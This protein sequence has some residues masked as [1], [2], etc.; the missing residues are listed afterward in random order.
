M[1]N[2]LL[3]K[4]VQA[5]VSFHGQRGCSSHTTGSPTESPH[6]LSTTK[7]TSRYS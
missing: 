6:H 4:L 3:A 1:L 7:S 2:C 5:L